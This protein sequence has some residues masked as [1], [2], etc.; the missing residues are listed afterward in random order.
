MASL[1]ERAFPTLV[2][3]LVTQKE[4]LKKAQEYATEKGIPTSELVEARLYE[5]MYPLATQVVI[6][7]TTARETVT[8]LTGKKLALLERRELTLDE[9]LAALDESIQ[10]LEDV[11]P[12]SVSV[13]EADTVALRTATREIPMSAEA[14][15]TEYAIANAF[16][17]LNMS[18]AILRMKGVPLGKRDYLKSF[19]RTINIG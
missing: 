8:Q 3:I 4:L 10:I 6:T 18:Y 5:D 11:K 17:H 7:A 13:K 15:V 14:Y 1:Y 9:C 2:S 19:W 12:E 16:F